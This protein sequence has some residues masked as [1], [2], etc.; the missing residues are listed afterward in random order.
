MTTSVLATKFVFPYLRLPVLAVVANQIKEV[1][2]FWGGRFNG[3][4]CCAVFISQK[5][6]SL[7]QRIA[8][9]LRLLAQRLVPQQERVFVGGNR[10]FVERPLSYFGNTVLVPILKSL[11]NAGVC[12]ILQTRISNSVFNARVCCVQNLL[13]SHIPSRVVVVKNGALSVYEQLRF[14]K[15]RLVILCHST[16]VRKVEPPSI[17]LSALAHADIAQVEAVEVVWAAV[18]RVDARLQR[19]LRLF[20][21]PPGLARKRPGKVFR[22]LDHDHTTALAFV[23]T[24]EHGIERL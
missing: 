2:A 22:T 20:Q 5:T 19:L 11:Q 15:F 4:Y 7:V 13:P 16:R 24:L 9:L 17:R 21:R 6:T 23:A 12:V 18:P 10:H 14:C 3:S 1:V 8:H